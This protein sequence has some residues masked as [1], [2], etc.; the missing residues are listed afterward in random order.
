MAHVEGA[1][2]VA[3]RIAQIGAHRLVRRTLAR[4]RLADVYVAELEKGGLAPPRRLTLSDANERPSDFTADGRAV[5]I[6]SDARGG[7]GSFALPLDRAT[8]EPIADTAAW[9]TWP[10]LAPADLGVMYWSLPEREPFGRGAIELGG[11]TIFTT[12]EPKVL[13]T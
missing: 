10:T 13:S 7:H 12:P 6:V 5:L 1:D 8:A 2:L 4:A 9:T 3:V 11:R